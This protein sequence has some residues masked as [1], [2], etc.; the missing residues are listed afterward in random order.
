MQIPSGSKV[1]IIPCWNRSIISK[2]S[3]YKANMKIINIVG[4]RPQFIKAALV[5]RQLRDAGFK[6]ILVHTG[7]HYDLN[8]SDIFFVELKI[9]EPDYHLGIGSGPHGKQTG[10]M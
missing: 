8:M 1:S 3:A 4:A 5:C 9:P 10:R 6:E 7:Q 2:T